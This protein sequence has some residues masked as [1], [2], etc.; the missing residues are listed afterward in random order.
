MKSPATVAIATFAGDFR[1]IFLRGHKIK[2]C[3]RRQ[4]IFKFAQL[5]DGWKPKVVVRAHAS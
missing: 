3:P 2:P 5:R 1:D 4:W